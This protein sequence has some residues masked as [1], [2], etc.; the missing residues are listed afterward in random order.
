M[1][2]G[3]EGSITLFLALT[4]VL[5]FGLLGTLVETARLGV[6][7]NHAAR[8]LHTAA[9]G[10]LAEY[11]RPLY[12]RYG[13]FFL[14][15]EGTAYEKVIA[16]YAADMMEP[17]G[18]SKM[19]FLEGIFDEIRVVDKQCAGDEEAE[20]LQKEITAYMQRRLTKKQWE[21]FC[22]KKESL[23]ESGESAGEIEKT[24]ETE[25]ELAKADKTVLE[26]MK[27]VDGIS[28]SS[29]EIQCENTFVKG[30]SVKKEKKGK[31]FGVMEEAVFKK[32]KKKIDT[33]PSDWNKLNK[34]SFLQKMEKV[35]PVAE[36]AVKKG[37][38]LKTCYHSIVKK[39]G[40]EQEKGMIAGMI[41]GLSSLEGNLRIFRETK[42]LLQ[43]EVTKETKD[44]L[45]T[46]WKD[47][48]TES[49]AFDYTGV[50]EKG[51]AE[52]P[53]DTLSDV[54]DGGILKLVC[55]EYDNLPDGTVKKPD[56]YAGYY[57]SEEKEDEDFGKRVENFTSKEEVK[58]SGAAEGVS[59]AWDEYCL[60]SYIGDK[61]GNAMEQKTEKESRLLYGWEYIVAGKDGD[62][63]NLESVLNRILMIRTVVNFTALFRDSAKKKEAYAAAAAIVGFT[64]MEPLIRFTQ[65]LILVV[66]SMVESFV[67]IAGL[68]QGRHVPLIKKPSE[69][70][71]GF[72][73]LF[74]I[75][76]ETV[77][78]G[79][80]KLK[81]GKKKS[82]GYEEYIKIFLLSVSSPVKRYRIL[83]LIRWDMR[84]NGYEGFDPGRCVY[85]I[86]VKGTAC[87]PTRL[88]RLASVENI[89]KRDL[90]AYHL[91]SKI[92]C[93]YLPE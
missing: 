35:I 18:K 7:A 61:F 44:T 13:L 75:S 66:W 48:D 39:N 27:L 79:A 17:G 72:A 29:G 81:E 20:A 43:G 51:G 91:V 31:C 63:A 41:G 52:N 86:T 10:L 24:V 74:A 32:M 49:V 58:L 73:D 90:K 26:L 71:T 15:Q 37:K 42:T 56:Y 83:D 84:K 68:L 77:L 23:E 55:E 9:E 82:F 4:G 87:F 70:L 21:K 76:R 65:T 22:K 62:R 11:S 28:V 38:E 59:C 89:L 88:F 80:K 54:W 36:K 53:L 3:R 2:R 5:I 85:S 30:F 60:L 45:K 69:I 40:E 78:N 64:G 50:E 46:L 1:V 8:T 16:G 57:E 34:K 47:Y 93:A 25:R 14:E 92:R 33:T 67:D 6:C 12:E 19:N